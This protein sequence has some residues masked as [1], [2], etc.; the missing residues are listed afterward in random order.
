MKWIAKNYFAK[1]HASLV[2]I[3][4]AGMKA[5]ELKKMNPLMA[6]VVLIGMIIHGF[7][8]MPIAPYIQKKNVDISASSLGALVTEI[9]FD[10]LSRRTSSRKK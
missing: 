3:L 4:E 10:G 9:F 2:K 1:N 5:G 7:I 6:V 8:Y